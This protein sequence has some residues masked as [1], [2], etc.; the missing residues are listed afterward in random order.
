MR[1]C[2]GLGYGISRHV[3]C[4]IRS[5]AQP[6][7]PGQGAKRAYPMIESKTPD[8][9]T[10]S[11]GWPC[12]R[13]LAMD[14]R[15]YLISSQVMRHA[16]HPFGHSQPGRTPHLACDIKGAFGQPDRAAEVGDP[17]V[18]EMQRADQPQL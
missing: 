12:N 9:G 10:H 5:T 8:I 15:A 18:E 4:F 16:Q 17:G 7:R 3:S 2:L 1:E 13:T 6:L 11:D 14:E